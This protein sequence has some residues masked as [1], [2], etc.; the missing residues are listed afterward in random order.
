MD[1]VQITFPEE[2]GEMREILIALLSEAG[3]ESFQETDEQVFAFIPRQN[4]NEESMKKSLEGSL[5][6]DRTFEMGVISEKNWNKLWEQNFEAVVIA[7]RCR[8]IAPFHTSSPAYPYEIIIEPQMSFG[9]AHHATTALMIEQMLEVDFHGKRVLDMG[10]GTGIL[11]IFAAMK[12]AGRIIAI[13]NNLWAYQNTLHNMELNNIENIEVIEGEKEAIPAENLDIVLA[14][15]NRNVLLEDIPAY[16]KKLASGGLL[17]LSGFLEHDRERI[18]E[19]CRENGLQSMHKLRKDDWIA[20][21]FR[22]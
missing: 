1:Y 15:I 19:K 11:A 22:K 10:C 21:I 9:T 17:L 20:E 16:V 3:F 12:K 6:S 8:V 5:F 7:G 2:N 14:N 18:L 4:Y 13:D